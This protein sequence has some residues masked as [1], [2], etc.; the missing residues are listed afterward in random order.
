MNNAN[1]FN[2]VLPS[3]FTIHMI[4][5]KLNWSHLVTKIK[6]SAS[7]IMYITI[8][9]ATWQIPSLNIALWLDGG[10]RGRAVGAC[11]GGGSKVSASGSEKRWISNL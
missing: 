1:Y 10:G 6:I 8:S 11:G 3:L 5:L 4:K 9:I 7:N 2:V